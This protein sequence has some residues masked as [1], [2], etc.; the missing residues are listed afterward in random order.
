MPIITSL[1]D[2]DF[3]KFTMAQAIAMTHIAQHRTV[4]VRFAFQNRSRKTHLLSQVVDIGRLREELE[5]VRTL[6]F[7]PDEIEFLRQCPGYA[8]GLFCQ[9]FLLDLARLELPPVEVGIRDGEINIET[10]GEWPQVTFW[11]TIVL[12][13][14]NEL[15][16]EEMRRRDGT[17]DLI[18]YA[19]WEHL[20]NGFWPEGRDRLRAK[21]ARIKAMPSA[22]IIEFGT[23]RRHT[24]YWQET[25]LEELI[26]GLPGQL[27]GTSNVR[28]AKK[29]GIKPVGT[30]AH[31]MPM[32]YAAIAHSRGKDVRQS[33]RRML[34]DWHGLYY[35]QL[36]VALTDTFGT[37]FFFQEMC[38]DRRRL[39]EEWQSLRH[40][41]GSPFDFGEYAV[42]FY[43]SVGIDPKTKGIVFSDNLNVE[44]IE[45]LVAQFDG[46]IQLSFGWGTDLTNDL[47]YKPLS[48]VMK[49]AE[50]NGYPTVKLSDDDGK[51]WGPQAAVEFY[52][53][54]FESKRPPVERD[55]TT[56]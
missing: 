19:A 8:P 6:R 12:S 32:C 17:Q 54:V 21:I 48:L 53:K 11:E 51:H 3:Y 23:R 39:A 10:V 28:L 44:V 37:D 7:T 43:E 34:D 18:E 38:D 31:E 49:A 24:A 35:S 5:H 50:A 4:P 9:G 27:L 46:R 16:Y 52:K 20:Y 55:W 29:Y 33:H 47:G 42:R 25:V 40:D 26:K 15:Y 14:V 2:V 36:S 56:Y 45:K 30:F 13:V 1:L 22:R 41:S